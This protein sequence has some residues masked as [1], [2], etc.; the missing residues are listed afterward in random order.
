MRQFP[1]SILSQGA[2]T[3]KVARE[4]GQR[5]VTVHVAG[6]GLPVVF[7]NEYAGDGSDVLAACERIGCAPFNLVVASR[8]NWDECLSPWPAGR[9]V[10]KDDHFT[11]EAPA[12]LS[13]I[14][15]EVVP[16]ARQAPARPMSLTPATTFSMP[17]CVW[18]RASPGCCRRNR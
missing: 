2:G 9:V 1:P 15:D 12:Y 18:P 7:S 14:L 5:A 10:T 6:E 3:Q 11:G 13:W 16:F 8:M 4:F 17:I